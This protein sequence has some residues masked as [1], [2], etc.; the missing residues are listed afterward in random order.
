MITLH[1]LTR[2]H[3]S[4]GAR[5]GAVV[6]NEQRPSV[7]NDAPDGNGRENMPE[8]VDECVRRI[9]LLLF[10]NARDHEEDEWYAEPGEHSHGAAE[11]SHADDYRERGA[12]DVSEHEP[13]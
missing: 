11:A 1:S 7:E 2:R 13:L 3:R 4:R 10:R 8:A 5:R 9:E 12:G 6:L